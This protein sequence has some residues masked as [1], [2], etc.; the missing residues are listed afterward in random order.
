[1]SFATEVDTVLG[2]IRPL[3]QSD[4]ADFE[5]RSVDE[6][7][8]TV[9]IGLVLDGVECLECVMPPEFLHQMVSQAVSNKLAGATLVLEDPRQT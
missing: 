6:S 9:T 4:G 1:M 7:S 3:V 8:R 2:E 5:L